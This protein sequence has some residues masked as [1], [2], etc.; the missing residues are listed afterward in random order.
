MWLH[1]TIEYMQ[2]P[3][4]T[5]RHEEG[6]HEL[7]LTRTTGDSEPYCKTCNRYLYPENR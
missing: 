4:D 3:I 7:A 5:D 2:C 1:T 6:D